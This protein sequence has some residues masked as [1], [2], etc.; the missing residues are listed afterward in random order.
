MFIDSDCLNDL[1]RLGPGEVDRQQ[2]VFQVRAQHLHPLRKD[3][4]AL[5]MA[6]SD[7]TM[8]VLPSFVVML[9]TANHELIFLNGYIEL[10]A[11]K[12]RHRQCDPQP[13]WLAVG[14]VAPLD[15]V[16]RITVGALDDADKR[17]LGL[18]ESQQERTG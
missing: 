12:T 18:L 16:G 2:P 15:I 1:L 14:T 7:A 8:N 17:T 9:P 10:V 5:E 3:K 11:G 4:S 13:F 6:R